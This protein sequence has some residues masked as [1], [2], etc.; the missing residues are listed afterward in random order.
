LENKE[1]ENHHMNTLFYTVQMNENGE[2]FDTELLEE[3]HTLFFGKLKRW[4]KKAVSRTR[5]GFKRGF[6]KAR[7]G[8]KRGFAKARGG[9]TKGF[10]K[11]KYG[12]NKGFNKAKYGVKKGFN[13]AKQGVKKAYNKAKQGVEKAYKTAMAKTKVLINKAKQL[14]C[15]S[16]NKGVQGINKSIDKV[17]TKIDQSVK[18]LAK[19]A[20]LAKIP[21]ISAPFKINNVTFSAGASFNDYKL[22]GYVSLDVDVNFGSKRKVYGIKVG[23]LKVSE[24]GSKISQLVVKSIK[25]SYGQLF[26]VTFIC[27]EDESFLV[28]VELVQRYFGQITINTT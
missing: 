8:F 26:T 11:A 2:L 5:S 18:M 6:A 10:N 20:S 14:A 13:K 12:I 19:L 16:I 21:Q 7:G 17:Q 27:T 3:E 9:I 28:G 15:K 4:A 22:S 1:L 25:K 23:S 24:I